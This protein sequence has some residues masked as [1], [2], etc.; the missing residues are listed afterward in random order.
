MQR[1]V[2]VR[3]SGKIKLIGTTPE[4]SAVY[5]KLTVGEK[6]DVE[7]T[8]SVD[9]YTAIEGTL[10]VNGGKLNITLTGARSKGIAQ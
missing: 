8:S 5:G 3:G 1:D 9:G 7:I 10:A 6:G 4:R 2:D